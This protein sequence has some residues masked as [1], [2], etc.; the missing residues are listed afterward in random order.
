LLSLNLA[1]NKLEGPIGSAMKA[2][3][4]KNHTLIDL[5]VGFNSFS[6]ADVS[7]LNFIFIDSSHI[8]IAYK[9]Q[10]FI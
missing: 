4:D 1:N 3:L 2:M 7:M 5:E 9:K 10:S 6:I 8:K